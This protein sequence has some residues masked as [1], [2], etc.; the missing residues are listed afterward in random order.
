[1]LKLRIEKVRGPLSF[2]QEM[3]FPMKTNEVSTN[4]SV[5]PTPSEGID[6]Y[7]LESSSSSSPPLP[8]LQPRSSGLRPCR[9]DS[10]P[11]TLVTL[12]SFRN[13]P[14]LLST[15]VAAQYPCLNGDISEVLDQALVIVDEMEAL[16]LALAPSP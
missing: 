12:A 2:H 1:M 3:V 5:D 6:R 16:I 13:G 7:T 11:P 10:T 4:N 8:P 9:A 14:T 15:S